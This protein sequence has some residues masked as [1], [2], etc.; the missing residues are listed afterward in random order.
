MRLIGRRRCDILYCIVTS[1]I[2]Y[3]PYGRKGTNCP[4]SSLPVIGTG[5]FTEKLMFSL[6]FIIMLPP[7][8]CISHS[9]SICLALTFSLWLAHS[10]SFS[11]PLSVHHSLSL[12]LSLSLSVFLSLSLSL[13]VSFFHNYRDTFNQLED[14]SYLISL[15]CKAKLSEAKRSTCIPSLLTNIL[16]Q[17][18]SLAMNNTHKLV[19]LKFMRSHEQF[20]CE[21]KS[22]KCLNIQTD[23][24]VGIITHYGSGTDEDLDFIF[25]VRADTMRGQG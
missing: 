4:V 1:V 12:S 10:S 25:K 22:R 6:F 8:V 14:R 19:A 17:P 24:V 23:H 3:C 5:L 11:L 2:G 16:C 18:H 15:N 21:L 7:S 9:L 13:S 20:S